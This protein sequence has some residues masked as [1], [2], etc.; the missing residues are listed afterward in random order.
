MPGSIKVSGSQRTVASPYIKVGGAWRQVAAGYIKVSGAWRVWHSADI[1]DTFNRTNS[2]TLGTASNGIA[3]WS[4]VKGSWGIADGR[5][6]STTEPSNVALA[7]TTL[8]K[9]TSNYEIDVDIPSGAG[10]GAAFWVTDANNWWAA[11]TYQDVFYTQTCPNGGTLSGNNCVTTSSYSARAF[12][13]DFVCGSTFDS[14]Q[15]RNVTTSTSWVANGLAC[16]TSCTNSGGSC[17][18]GVCK[19]QQTSTSCSSLSPVVPG[20][21]SCWTGGPNSCNCGYYASGGLCYASATGYDCPFGGNLDGTT[22]T[23]TSSYP[24]T[25]VTNYIYEVRIIQSVNGVIATRAT[26]TDDAETKSLKVLTVGNQITVR[27]YNLVGQAGT[28]GEVS[29]TASSPSIT[30]TLGIVK[31]VPVTLSLPYA[32]ANQTNFVDNFKAK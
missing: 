13:Y 28:A 11:I 22:C 31:S 14:T 29:F 27:A 9:A 1:V 24:A 20:P 18:D 12:S 4:T 7:T 6:S 19:V 15:Y 21:T 26:W 17:R 16:G 5:A 30:G 10:V 23:V 32:S 25:Q 8:I 3:Q 2:S